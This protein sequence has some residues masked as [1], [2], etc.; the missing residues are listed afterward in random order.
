MIQWPS[1]Y[2]W[3]LKKQEIRLKIAFWTASSRTVVHKDYLAGLFGEGM[4]V[5]STG[6]YIRLMNYLP[7]SLKQIIHYRLIS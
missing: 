6:Y 3:A 7:V 2:F 5:L 1:Y 4:F